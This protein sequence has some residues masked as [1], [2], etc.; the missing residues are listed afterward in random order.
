M[1][2]MSP[3]GRFSPECRPSLDASVAKRG[4][5]G[6]HS[7]ALAGPELFSSFRA[8]ILP[9]SCCMAPGGNQAGQASLCRDAVDSTCCLA[10][11]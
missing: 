8:E 10:F 1:H 11:S 4:L 9:N 7:H 2:G 3:Q 5:A 6:H